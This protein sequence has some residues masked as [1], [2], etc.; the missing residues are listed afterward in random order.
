MSKRL[1]EVPPQELPSDEQENFEDD[2]LE[3]WETKLLHDE[4]QPELYDTLEVLKLRD[5]IN[6]VMLAAIVIYILLGL[7]SFP[8]IRALFQ[9]IIVSPSEMSNFLPNI[10]ATIISIS[11]R[12]VITYSVL[13]ALMQILRILME[14][15]FNSRKG[16][17]PNPLV[18]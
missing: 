3:E 8:F 2:G 16:I 17:K 4:N 7:L 1:G 12:I 6:K 18:E 14:I 9:G 5:N 13:K 11:F 15:E 10:I